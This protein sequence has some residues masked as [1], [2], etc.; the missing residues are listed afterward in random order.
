MCLCVTE[1]E[2]DGFED[3]RPQPRKLALEAQVFDYLLW[4]RL[5]SYRFRIFNHGLLLG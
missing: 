5:L 4:S 2:A 1:G 3:G